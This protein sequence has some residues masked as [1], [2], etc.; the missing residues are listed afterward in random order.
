MRY[1]CNKCGKAAY[2]DG[3]CGDGPILMCGHGYPYKAVP[4]DDN[5]PYRDHGY[6]GYDGS[7]YTWD[8]R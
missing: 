1:V 4:E 3:R 6:D 7:S 2:Y 5:A 8:S